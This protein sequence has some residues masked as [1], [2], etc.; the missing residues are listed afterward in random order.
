MA[1]DRFGSISDLQAGRAI[2]WSNGLEL[3]TKDEQGNITATL[4]TEKNYDIFKSALTFYEDNANIYAGNGNIMFEENRVLFY[5]ASIQS[6]VSLRDTESDF[7]AL[8]YPKYNESDESYRNRNFGSSYFA[9]PITAKNA[10]MSATVLEAQNFY[11]YRDVRPAYYDTILKGKVSRDEDT[12]EMFD[13]ILDT[14]YVDTFFVYG[15]NLNSVADTPFT[16]VLSG[17]DIYM[18][19][20]KTH[21][22][23]ISKLLGKM[24]ESLS[25]QPLD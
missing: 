19:S 13:L 23:V 25:P 5:M 12:R 22:K 15:S 1:N 18:S 4:S 24:I 8:P 11:S 20:M 9:I 6:G 3:C 21:E 17:N 16:I 2:L 10:E 7:G 14:C